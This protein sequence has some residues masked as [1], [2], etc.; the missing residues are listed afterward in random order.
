MNYAPQLNLCLKPQVTEGT[1]SVAQGAPFSYQIIATRSPS[2]YVAFN[3]PS[4]LSVD[5]NTGLIT[6]STDAA[7]GTYIVTLG[8]QNGAGTGTGYLYITVTVATLSVTFLSGALL[9][10]DTFQVSIDGSAYANVVQ[11][12]EYVALSQIKYKVVTLANTYSSTNPLN[13][14]LGP[15]FTA[16]ADRNYTATAKVIG[17]WAGAN[18]LS[19]AYVSFQNQL[20]DGGIN[21]GNLSVSSINSSVNFSGTTN[22]IAIHADNITLTRWDYVP[23]RTFNAC[24]MEMIINLA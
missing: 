14:G 16:S 22:S 3:L 18:P 11:G 1:V 17:S 12:L 13:I 19:G 24:T 15:N 8:A 21:T 23:S 7:L 9:G 4:G 10:K 20:H 5:A 6:G 2:V